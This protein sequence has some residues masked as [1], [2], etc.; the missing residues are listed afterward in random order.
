MDTYIYTAIAGTRARNRAILVTLFVDDA[1]LIKFER[2]RKRSFG[3]RRSTTYLLLLVR[4]DEQ[5]RQ[6]Q[7]MTYI[8]STPQ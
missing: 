7:R 2:K 6:R 4:Q 8:H 1:N 3:L 5:N